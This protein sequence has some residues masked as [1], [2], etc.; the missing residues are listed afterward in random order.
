VISAKQATLNEC[1]SI[2]SVEDVYLM[3]EIIAIDAHNKR[4]AEEWVERNRER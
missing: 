3:V 4:V 2:Y 1:E